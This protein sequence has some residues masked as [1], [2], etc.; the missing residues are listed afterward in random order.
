MNYVDFSDTTHHAIL[1]RKGGKINVDTDTTTHDSVTAEA[2]ALLTIDDDKKL[3]LDP[4]ASLSMV[5]GEKGIGS[6]FFGGEIKT[7]FP[8]MGSITIK[9]INS[10]SYEG[11][12][13]LSELTGD[14]NAEKIVTTKEISTL[15]T[16][17]ETYELG[18]SGTKARI[19]D[20]DI[21]VGISGILYNDISGYSSRVEI[22]KLSTTIASDKLITNDISLKDYISNLFSG[23]PIT[24]QEKSADE[25]TYSYN[26]NDGAYIDV[27]TQDPATATN[28]VSIPTNKDIK[29]RKPATM[30]TNLSNRGQGNAPVVTFSSKSGSGTE[31][32]SC[33]GDNRLLENANFRTQTRVT[34]KNSI[35]GNGSSYSDLVIAGK[36]VELR[37]GDTV[38]V[39][40]LTTETGA[41]LIIRGKMI[42]TDN[43]DN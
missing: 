14:A 20:K 19:N 42:F 34:E 6:M 36:D 15:S 11:A 9:G 27:L 5:Y 31:V 2:G 24:L 29:I 16:G 4:S 39:K 10:I 33:S 32:L 28:V 41:S 1:V 22:S 12:P 43:I 26:P 38:K 18:V 23:F 8:Y 40:K 30:A 25:I 3:T 37:K 13:N 35:A 17:S 7:R 21:P